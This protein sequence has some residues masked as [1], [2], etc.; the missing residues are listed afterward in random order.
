MGEILLSGVLEIFPGV[1][2]LFGLNIFIR[3]QKFTPSQA[4][5]MGLT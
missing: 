3:D 5:T 1:I 4:L 2:N